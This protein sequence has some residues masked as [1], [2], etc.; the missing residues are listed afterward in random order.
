MRDKAFAALSRPQISILGRLLPVL[1]ASRSKRRPRRHAL[2]PA[3]RSRWAVHE[4]ARRNGRR[5][6]CLTKMCENLLEGLRLSDERSEPNVAA[7]VRALEWKLLTNSGHQIHRFFGLRNYG[8]RLAEVSPIRRIFA[9]H[10][11]VWQLQRFMLR[12]ERPCKLRQIAI[13]RVVSELLS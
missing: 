6:E 1:P 3:R 10:S 2:P 8:N 11:A 13:H 5:L 9:I 4:V 7:T 12:C